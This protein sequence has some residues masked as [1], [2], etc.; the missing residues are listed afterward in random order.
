MSRMETLNPPPAIHDDEVFS[1]EPVRWF[2]V[3]ESSPYTIIEHC[4]CIVPLLLT[5]SQLPS[6][7]SNKSCVI[8]RKRVA[9]DVVNLVPCSNK[10]IERVSVAF[11]H[12]CSLFQHQHVMQ[13]W[14]PQ[15]WEIDNNTFEASHLLYC[16]WQKWL[17]GSVLYCRRDGGTRWHNSI[18]F[19]PL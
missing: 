13:I 1:R 12:Y 11:V 19:S 4:I 8:Q 6:V 7:I 10:L 2:L 16:E 5:P 18:D 17:E 14:T 15:P 3:Q 9:H